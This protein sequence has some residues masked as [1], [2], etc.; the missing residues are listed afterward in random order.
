[1]GAPSPEA[2]SWAW[3]A[4]VVAVAT[5]LVAVL[6]VLG[7]DLLWAVALGDHIVRTGNVPAGLPFA[8][9]PT[10]EWRNP[11]VLGEVLL[12]LLGRLGDGALLGALV[13]SVAATLCLL[14]VD[15]RRAGASDPSTAVTLIAVLV[16][17][18]AAFFIMR[19]Q[20]FS[21]A[22]FAALLLVLRKDHETPSGRIWLVVPILALWA[23]LHG[24][25]L[26]GLALAVCYL[27]F[28]RLRR[29]PRSSIILMAAAGL[30]LTTT[31]AGLHYPRYIR[32][33]F[34]NAAAERGEQMWTPLSVHSPLD[35]LF[36]TAMAA[37]AYLYFRRP[38][39]VWEYVAVAGLGIGT[40]VSARTGFWL[41]L[42]IAAPAA[43]AWAGATADR[44]PKVPARGAA[45]V[46]VIATVLGAVA[47][48]TRGELLLGGNAS[49]VRAVVREAG[50][51]V[52]LAEEPLVEAIAAAGGTI[53]AGNPLDAFSKGDQTAYL[54][55]VAG[56]PGGRAAL[57]HADL[58]VARAREPASR[59]V[60]AD[61]RFR[62][63]SESGGW[64]VYERVP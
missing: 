49:V 8:A 46:V 4:C 33:V 20:V 21:P 29:R 11:F 40:A 24:T 30:A 3:T 26:V 45:V 18:L 62:Q 63:V 32:G 25:V 61:G 53:W 35:V 19:I 10:G 23:N 41:L 58:V 9:A 16:A 27:L 12:A 50:S 51:G 57:N 5:I 43:G 64:Q 36:L 22:L 52:V 15:M 28:G 55:F 56:R 60:L 2:E 17:G 54:D 31:S 47:A 37:L 1:M 34:T 42:F 6:G 44:G 13:V 59:L 7:A 39:P 14:A 48:F 38:R